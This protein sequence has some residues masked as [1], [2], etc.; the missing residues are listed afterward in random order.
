MSYVLTFLVGVFLGGF[1]MAILASAG[2][3]EERASRVIRERSFRRHVARMDS[4]SR[5]N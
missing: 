1:F 4:E 2:R 5:L 3:G